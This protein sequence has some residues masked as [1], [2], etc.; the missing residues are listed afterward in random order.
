MPPNVPADRVSAMRRAFDATMKD[1]GFLA[2]AE[3]LKIE[4]DP[5]SGEEVAKL[6]EHP[7]GDGSIGRFAAATIQA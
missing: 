3:K 5:L 2:E 4:V 7:G 6:V 1:P